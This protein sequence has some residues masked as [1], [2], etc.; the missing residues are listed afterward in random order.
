MASAEVPSVKILYW[1]L[2]AL[3]SVV[4]ALSIYELNMRASETA[5]VVKTV[6]IDSQRISALEAQAVATQRQLDR[7]DGKLDQLLERPIHSQ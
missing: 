4:M 7:I 5:S 3:M 1:L 2:G 6:A